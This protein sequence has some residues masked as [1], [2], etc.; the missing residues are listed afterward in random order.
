MP[1]VILVAMAL[2]EAAADVVAAGAIAVGVGTGT[3]FAAGELAVNLAVGLGLSALS[4]SLRGSSGGVQAR[5][6]RNPL[7]SRRII[8][9]K[10]WTAGAGLPE[11]TWGPSNKYLEKIIVLADHPCDGFEQ[12]YIDGYP[13]T[14][15]TFDSLK[16]YPILY[17]SDPTTGN[18]A[19]DFREGKQKFWIMFHWGAD[20]Q[21]AD[22]WLVNNIGP[23][24]A[25]A[26]DRNKWSSTKVGTNVSYARITAYYDSDIFSG[27]PQFNFFIR[28]IPLYDPT[29]DST[30]GGYGSHRWGTPSTYE[31]TANRAVH[32]YNA[33]RG[34]YLGGKRFYGAFLDSQDVPLDIAMAAIVACDEEVPLRAGGTEPRYHGGLEWEVTRPVRDFFKVCSE[35]MAGHIGTRGH[36]AIYAGVAQ[37][38]VFTF[39]DGDCVRGGDQEYRPMQSFGALR[40]QVNAKFLDITQQFAIVDAPPRASNDDLAAD[41]GI[42]FVDSLNLDH[43]QS[44]PTCQRIMEIQRKKHR[45]QSTAVRTFFP[46]ALN[47]R[48]GQWIAGTSSAWTGTKWFQI[49]HIKVDRQFRTV[50]MELREVPYDL[51]DWNPA[52]DELDGYSVNLPT[53]AAPDPLVATGISATALSELG[54]D[55]SSSSGF[56]VSYTPPDDPSVSSVI[57]RWRL[58]NDTVIHYVQ[59]DS[60]EDGL[61]SVR[62]LAGSTTYEYAI[63]LSGIP[64]RNAIWSAWYTVTT[65]K[66]NLPVGSVG[67]DEAKADIKDTM[68]AA[69]ASVSTL[70]DN[71]LSSVQSIVDAAAAL[72]LQAQQ[73]KQS[74]TSQTTSMRAD[75]TQ[76][77]TTVVT[78]VT[79]LAD[80]YN[81]VSASLGGKVSSTVFT[82]YQASVTAEFA[83]QATAITGVTARTDN[84]WAQGLIRIEAITDPAGFDSRVQISAAGSAGGPTV[85]AGLFIGVKTVGG[86]AQSYIDLVAD[87]FRCITSDGTLISLLTSAGF[88]VNDRILTGSLSNASVYSLGDGRTTKGSDDSTTAPP[89]GTEVA[90]GNGQSVP[91]YDANV[92]SSDGIAGYKTDPTASLV[93]VESRFVFRVQTGAGAAAKAGIEYYNG[94]SWVFVPDSDDVVYTSN[95]NALASLVAKAPL[96]SGTTYWRP[97]IWNT[98]G[99]TIW[100]RRMRAYETKLIK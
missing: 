54:E 89:D 48:E 57:I 6:E 8:W 84:I 14:L 90:V 60:P 11:I 75:Y 82:D 69:T 55:G 67:W 81:E 62:G 98:T 1:P 95:T 29:K 76:Q 4:N 99:N 28:G 78:N 33:A 80:L 49:E 85:A 96:P 38:P 61:I 45:A 51:D 74:L 30:V 52:N 58:P 19:K 12:I 65:P 22:Q 63:L 36:V 44:G 34:V 39:S 40:N 42:P 23:G 59:S 7:S 20:G 21:T 2:A 43:V 83:S 72:G 68:A 9:G 50:R 37:T 92:L 13:A 27:I 93:E 73:L 18:I 79:A 10:A 3:A 5:E 31:W 35:G 16:G 17:T 97:R 71:M 26:V 24:A 86:V 25:Y 66:T 70:R 87:R 47:A 56:K 100:V 64:G 46:S 77:I 32:A 15:G 53:G 94:I 88:V 91:Y 41:G